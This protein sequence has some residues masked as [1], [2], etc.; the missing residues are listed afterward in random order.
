LA[1][2]TV[3]E[4]LVEALK[5]GRVRVSTALVAGRLRARGL[6]VTVEQVAEVFRRYGVEAGKKTVP[7]S[8]R[9]KG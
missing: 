3:I 9:S 2:T 7:G 4:V 6:D 5:A 1:T 8:K